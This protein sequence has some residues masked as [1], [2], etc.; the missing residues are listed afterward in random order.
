MNKTADGL[1]TTTVECEGSTITVRLEDARALG[2]ALL[3]RLEEGD[4]VLRDAILPPVRNLEAWIDHDGRIRMGRWLL[5]TH[6]G[7]LAFVL[8]PASEAANRITQ[9]V[10][11]VKF[12]NGRWAVESVREVRIV[13]SRRR[14]SPYFAHAPRAA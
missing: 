2:R 14:P 10:A 3:G 11:P 4:P 5:D 1:E 6:F 7:T 9:Y 8:R 13:P 12:A